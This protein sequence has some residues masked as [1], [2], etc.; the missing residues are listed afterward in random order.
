MKKRVG[1]LIVVTVL[2]LALVSCTGNTAPTSEPATSE[3]ATSAP[4][5]VAPATSAEPTDDSGEKIKLGYIPM[6][7]S[8]QFFSSLLEGAKA[9]EAAHPDVELVVVDGANDVSKQVA[10]VE[11]LVNAGCKAMDLRCLDEAALADS[12][13]NTVAKGIYVTTYPDGM[14]GRSTGVAYDDYNRGYLLAKEATKWVNEK[15]GGKAEVAFLFEPDNQNAMKRIDAFHDVF[16]EDCPNATIVA[17]QRGF[18]TD[19]AMSTTESILQAHPDVKVI[20]CSNDAAGVGVYEAVTSAK[21]DTDD[22]FVGGIDGDTAAMDLI[23]KGGIYRCSVACK[24]L[25]QDIEWKVMQNM[26]DAVKT[27]K[28]VDKIVIEEFAVTK[29]TVD[30]YRSMTPSYGKDN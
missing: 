7:L 24:W 19:V 23:A 27:G 26:Y 17:E 2:V 15:L 1:F 11:N 9:F 21:K 29:D 12:V 28:F 10:G 18:T 4:A 16:A 22:F 5:S 30:A 3:P 13:K 14:E 25:T 8:V 6:D 20:I